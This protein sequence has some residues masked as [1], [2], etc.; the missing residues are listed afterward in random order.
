MAGSL[1]VRAG[2]DKRVSKTSRLAAFAALLSAAACG[3]PSV[4]APPASAHPV[5]ARAAAG[6]E[7]GGPGPYGLSVAQEVGLLIMS[8]YTGPLTQADLEDWHAHGYGGLLVVP[9]NDNATSS[10]DLAQQIAAV[11]AAAPAGL[12]AATDQ[13][14]GTVCLWDSGADCPQGARE[15][16]RLGPAYVGPAMADAACGLR[17][18]GFN[19]DFA[20]VTDVWDGVHPFM[21]DRSYGTD[22]T[23]VSGDVRAAV[24]GIHSCGLA[25]ASK[26]FPGEGTG[27]GDPHQPDVLPNLAHSLPTLEQVDWQPV[28]AAIASGVDL[29]MVGHMH[30]PSLAGDVPTSMSAAPIQ[31]LRG[32]LG[33]SG[34]IISDDLQMG[35]LRPRYP[36]PEAAALFLEHGGDMVIVSHSLQLA[37]Q[38]DAAII[39]AVESGAYPRSQLDASVARVVRLMRALG[40]SALGRRADLTP[41]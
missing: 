18:T 11:R 33:F 39:A 34:V 14:G 20:P 26:H 21:A 29:V 1:S 41:S 17:A 4:T 40:T 5:A 7:A 8:G 28:R 25:A 36:V 10:A 35:A 15:A 31:A 30:V 38:A 27:D 37:D 13:E 9:V 2:Y 24:G 19:I 12:L 23:A 22:A 32:Q 6:A 16:G 3:H